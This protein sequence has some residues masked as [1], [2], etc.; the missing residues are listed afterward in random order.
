MKNRDL[1]K[2]FLEV[3]KLE[4]NLSWRTLKAYNCDLG[5]FLKFFKSKK[6]NLLSIEDLREYLAYLEGKKL[7]DSTTKRKLATIKVLYS[8]LEDEGFIDI[9]PT[10]KLKKKYRISRRIPRVMSLDEIG[11]LLK[12]AYMMSA[13]KSHESI[14]HRFKRLRDRVILEILFATGIRIDELVRL[15]VDDLDV[16]ARTLIIFGKGRKERLIYISSD[17]VV[18]LINDYL[19]IRSEYDHS[20][21]A[22]LLNKF[23][24]RLSVHSIGNIFKEYCKIAGVIRKFT[25]HCLRHTMATMLVENGADVRSVQEILGHSRIS[26]TEIYLTV[27]KRRKEIVLSQFNQRNSLHI[28]L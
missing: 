28:A 15:N 18:N 22:F 6:I 23:G 8:F 12:A 3:S 14:F 11:R 10:K 25:P 4:K 19:K 1:V 17:E 21:S 16:I 27:S 20:S 5:D 9:S 13:G 7:A 24:N 26:T 2:R